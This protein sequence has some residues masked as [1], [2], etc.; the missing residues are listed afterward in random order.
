[1]D[2]TSLI[3]LGGFMKKKQARKLSGEAVKRN[4][5]PQL[6]RD[7]FVSKTAR[8]AVASVV[9]L[10]NKD[11]YAGQSALDIGAFENETAEVRF[12]IQRILDV[13]EKIIGVSGDGAIAAVTLSQER[14]RSSRTDLDS[15]LL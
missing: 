2:A 1:M 12:A 11:L 14:L 10:L 6:N 9:Q 7:E 15:T 3:L 13:F 4:R 8:K 5:T